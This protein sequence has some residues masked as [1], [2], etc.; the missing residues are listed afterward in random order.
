MKKMYGLM[1]AIAV[2]GLGN[3]AVLHAYSIRVFNNCDVDVNVT[4]TPTKNFL[5]AQNLGSSHEATIKPRGNA[6]IRNIS[7][8]GP[9]ELK[10]S[11]NADIGPNMRRLFETLDIGST[12]SGRYEIVGKYNQAYQIRR[13][14]D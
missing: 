7:V 9:Y 5:G 12:P 2:I 4:I 11:S 8:G 1:A 14:K 6:D 3:T 10:V 13:K